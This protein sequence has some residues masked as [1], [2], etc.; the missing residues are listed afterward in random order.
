MT[1][2]GAS[3]VDKIESR[4]FCMNH[5]EFGKFIGEITRRGFNLETRLGQA[6]PRRSNVLVL[7]HSSTG[8]FGH[9]MVGDYN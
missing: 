5:V 9:G 3:S 7:T 1:V 6:E 8:E 4:E 2:A